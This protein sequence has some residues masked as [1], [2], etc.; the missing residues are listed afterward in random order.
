MPVK[1]RVSRSSFLNS[2][3]ADPASERLRPAETFVRPLKK[4]FAN[5][6][7]TLYPDVSLPEVN[8]DPITAS[9]PVSPATV[10]SEVARV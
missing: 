8:R 4:K 9:A 7:K 1:C 10:M 2:T 6:R 5:F 3:M